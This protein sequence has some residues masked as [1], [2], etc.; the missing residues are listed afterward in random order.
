M[1]FG[2]IG[3]RN[4]YNDEEKLYGRVMELYSMIRLLPVEVLWLRIGVMLIL[5]VCLNLKI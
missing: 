1:R 4:Y 2:L 5:T 3:T